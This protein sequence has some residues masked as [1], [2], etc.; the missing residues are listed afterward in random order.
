[1]IPFDIDDPLRE[2][3]LNM[4]TK[5]LSLISKGLMDLKTCSLDHLKLLLD[6]S[7][8]CEQYEVSRLIQNEID[9]R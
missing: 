3:W 7:I 6:I 2:K 4:H 1:M 8:D 5:G 9:K